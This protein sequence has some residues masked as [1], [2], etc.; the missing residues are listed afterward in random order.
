V[1]GSIRTIW[2][3]NNGQ[4]PAP[5]DTIVQRVLAQTENNDGNIVLLHDGG[6]DR[7]HT[8]AAPAANHRRTSRE[9][10][11]SSYRFR[12]AWANSRA[13]DALSFL[14]RMVAGTRG[15][16]I[17]EVFRWLRSGIAFIF[18]TGIL[19]VGGRA[20]IIGL[21][22]LAEKLRPAP[23]DHPEYRPEVTI[24]I[25]A[26]NEEAVILNTV[27]AALASTYPKLEILVVDDGSADRTAE[28]VRAKL[29]ARPARTATSTDQ[30]RQ[31]CGAEPRAE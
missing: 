24:L 25:P 9:K 1:H 16:L 20:L 2:G 19:L 12:F 29:R 15:F 6:G 17:F 28:L 10:V 30:S 21:L 18:V 13:D 26:Y 5:A 22:A 7:S 14:P 11:T 4:P 31:A 27:Q 3:E 23:L 8:V